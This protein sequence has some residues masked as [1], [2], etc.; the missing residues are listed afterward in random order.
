MLD[1]RT[2]LILSVLLLVYYIFKK[3]NVKEGF[4][5]ENK[6]DD[7]LNK[8]KQ[9]YKE[10]KLFINKEIPFN[11]NSEHQKKFGELF[12]E[13]IKELT[14]KQF[15]IKLKNSKIRSRILSVLEKIVKL[16]K[17]EFGLTDNDFVEKIKEENKI[18]ILKSITMLEGKFKILKSKKSKDKKYMY[19]I[20]DLSSKL[21][22]LRKDAE[23]NR[24]KFIEISKK[25]FII[26]NIYEGNKMNKFDMD[27][28]KKKYKNN[29]DELIDEI[30]NGLKKF[31]E[32]HKSHKKSIN[33]EEESIFIK[34]ES[35][36]EESDKPEEEHK[37]IKNTLKTQVVEGYTFK[38][39]VEELIKTKVIPSR[40]EIHKKHLLLKKKI[41]SG[42]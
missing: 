12:G 8:E 7:T 6:E 2:I 1:T 35:E 41:A 3:C 22:F 13:E 21:E 26:K 5:V 14:K 20:E 23:L 37:K 42:M 27:E 33:S 30:E 34:E 18:N 9:T 29:K 19:L 4:I 16:R 17:N 31:S 39:L 36:P 38:K 10:K 40:K 25:F 28:L 32:F 24:E 15:N 11:L